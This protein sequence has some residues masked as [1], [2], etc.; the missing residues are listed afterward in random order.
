MIEPA[1]L[2]E[3]VRQGVSIPEAPLDSILCTE[4]L[5]NRPSRPPDHGKENSALVALISSLSDA[6]GTILQTLA[7]KVLQILDADSA[8]LSLLTRDGKRFYWAAIA[9]AWRPHVGGGTPRDFGPCGDVLDCNK[10]M[11]FT[12]WERRY[13]YLSAATPLAEEGLL[14]PFFVKSKA[15]GTIW[16]IAHRGHRK[17]DAEDLRVLESMGRFASA[18]YQTVQSIEDLNSEIATREKAQTDLRE[19]TNSLEQQV[20]AR[21]HELERSEADMAEAQQLSHTGSSRLNVRTGEISWSRELFAILDLDPENVRPS[22]SRYLEFIHPDDRARYDQVRSTAIEAKK[23]YDIEYRLL[24]PRGS[25]KHIHAVGHC[26]KSEL[27]DVE[28]IASVMDIT[29]QRLSEEALHAA[30]AALAHANRVAT[31]GEISAT[32][33]HEL[34]QPLAAI[35]TN[36][37]TGLRW[38]DRAEPN[39]A[40]ALSLFCSMVDDAQRVSG[41][42]DRVRAMAA[43]RPPQRTTLSLGDLVKESMA[44]LRPEFHSRAIVS[45]L[46]LEPE[47]LRLLGDR[48]QLQQVIV[49][50]ALNAVQAMV[51]SDTSD[52]RILIRTMQSDRETVCCTVEDSGPGID[53]ALLPQIFGSFVTTKEAGMGLGLPISKSIVEAHGGH[54]CADNESTLRGARFS[55]FLPGQQVYGAG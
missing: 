21:T 3:I 27:E 52:R 24:L 12:H 30:Q 20:R 16:A 8:G 2:E 6:P 43:R 53:A 5:R 39:V 41:I 26:L 45:V 1:N 55:F 54:I 38:L 7:D 11:L 9:G 47:S 10:P 48:T 15:V 13:P 35:L 28:Y 19:L 14:V 34:N 46:D 29:R 22:Y 49:N 40:K 25:I 36:A 18:A 50:L 33:A 4:E 37:E 17:F 31:L 32:I 23:D 51:Q 44:L 42:I